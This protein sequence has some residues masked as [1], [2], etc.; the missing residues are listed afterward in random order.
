MTIVPTEF[1]GKISDKQFAEF[2][3]LSEKISDEMV[4][5]IAGKISAKKDDIIRDLVIRAGSIIQ[6]RIEEVS[7]GNPFVQSAVN[8]TLNYSKKQ[9]TAIL[10]QQIKNIQKYL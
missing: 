3:T 10:A 9:L 6:S 8:T 7:K 5:R 4:K 1:E 2:D